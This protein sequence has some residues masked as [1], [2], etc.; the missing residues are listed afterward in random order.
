MHKDDT[1][2]VVK[3][4]KEGYSAKRHGPYSG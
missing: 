3:V 1:H 4:L 2:S